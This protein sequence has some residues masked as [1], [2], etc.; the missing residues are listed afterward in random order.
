MK[1][2]ILVTHLL[3]SGHLARALILGRAA[4][5]AGHTVTVIS[6]G[7]PAPHLPADGVRFV[8]LPPLSSDGVNFR[9]LLTE[10][11]APADEA[12][13]AERRALVAKTLADD[14]PDALVLELWP[15]GR[16]GLSDEFLAAVQAAFQAARAAPARPAVL[17][18]IRDV[19]ASASKPERIA[20]TAARV[21][22]LIDAVLVHGDRELLPL[23]AS[24]PGGGAALPPEIAAKLHYTGFVSE[25]FGAAPDSAQAA[26]D[27]RSDEVLVAAGGGPVGERLFEAAAGAAALAP[28][29]GWRLLVGG[30]PARVERLRAQLAAGRDQ[31]PPRLIVEPARPDYRALLRRAAC[32]VSQIGY[33]TALDLVAERPPAVLVPF[34]EGGETEQRLRAEALGARAGAVVLTEA[35]LDAAALAAAVRKAIA[36]GPLRPPPLNLGGAAHSVRVIEGAASRTLAAPV[37]VARGQAAPVQAAPFQAAPV[38]AAP[39][40]SAAPGD[41]I[42]APLEGALSALGDAGLRLPLW[43]R[44][45]DAVAPSAALDRLLALASGFEAPIAIA[46]IP[47]DATE[48]LAA[49]LADSPGVSVL[50][51]GWSHA[52]H[53]RPDAKK[54]EFGADRPLAERMAEARRGWDR[55]E[56]L[57]GERAAPIF[58]PPWNRIGEDAPPALAA[59]GL[60]GLSV[61]GPRR[62]QEAAPGLA[63]INIHIDPVDWRGTRSARPLGAIAQ[64]LA[65]YLAARLRGAV[66]PTEPVGLL[67]HHLIHDAAIW[68]ATARLADRLS[69]RRDVVEWIEAASVLGPSPERPSA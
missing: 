58:V 23:E 59:A 47:R 12:Y 30:G 7:R 69:R 4:A 16:R 33:N 9:R 41:A 32:S 42:W 5:A 52:N 67:T 27:A 46:S 3:G 48:D 28:D 31:A 51:H 40:L 61:S 44:D 17:C 60:R 2:T 18:S 63:A 26:A 29:L 14:P 54:A 6:G 11:G 20:E 56:A 15:F 36:R 53:A 49:R 64:R 25:F 35:G 68:D 21:S 62:A 8:Q 37:Q 1:L 66:D 39:R 38:H 10:T 57:F 22:A 24:W 13:R 50:P 45:D 43:W 19:L 34:E 65:D 55:I